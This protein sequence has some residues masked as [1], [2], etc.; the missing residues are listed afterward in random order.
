MNKP[1][2]GLILLLFSVTALTAEPCP[3]QG[4]PEP[5]RV[6]HVYDA[7]T[8][9]LQGGQRVRLLGIDAPELGRGGQA[10]EPFALEGRDFLRAQI[11]AADHQIEIHSGDDPRDRHGRRL[12]W[13]F[14]PDGTNLQRLLVEQGYAMQVVIGPNTAYSACIADAEARA[15]QARR[16]IWSRS[17]YAQGWQSTAL[18]AE[19]QGAIRLSGEVVRVGESRDNLWINLAGR[20]ALQLPKADLATF[21]GWDFDA[22]V[23][24]TVTVRGWL[25]AES[26]RHHDWRMRIN[27][28][29]AFESRH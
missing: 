8:L 10:H 28:P 5:A 1:L 23:G 7:D 9:T 19:A 17:E 6:A 29:Y 4:T 11:A 3:I 18:T 26:S 21:A 14:L 25:V 12:A 13:L 27:T 15:R 22:L 24:Q 2:L 20:V 16:G